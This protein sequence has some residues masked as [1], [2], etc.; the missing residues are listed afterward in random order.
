MS[1]KPQK[2]RENSKFAAPARANGGSSPLSKLVFALVAALGALALFLQHAMPRPLPHGALVGLGAAL[3]AAIGV[4]GFSGAI[5]FAR[6]ASRRRSGDGGLGRLPGEHWLV[7]LRV[8]LPLSVAVLVGGVA[9]FGYGGLPVTITC[10]LVALLPPAARRPGLLLAVLVSLLY[11]PLLGVSALWDPWETHYAEVAR[12]ILSRRDW[13]SLWWAQDGWFWSK[14]ILVFWSEALTMSALGVDPAPD[15]NPLHPEWALRLPVFAMSLAALVAVHALVRRMFGPRAGLLA[16]LVLATAPHFFLLAHQSITDMPL[17][18]CLTV[19]LCFLMLALAEDPAREPAVHSLGP[20]RLS[21]RTAALVALVLLALPQATYLISRN[22]SL[23]GHGLVAHEDSFQYGS[24][25][26]QGVSGNPKHQRS[27]PSARWRLGPALGLGPR[28]PLAGVDLA[29]PAAQGALWL[30]LL[31]IAAFFVARERRVQGLLMVG[32]YISCA[33]GL[34]AK[35]LPALALPGLIALLYLIGSGRFGALFRG[36]LRVALGISI[37]AVIGFPWYLAMS[38]R[39]GKPFLDRLLIHDHVNRLTSGVHGDSGSLQYFLREL[40]YALFP[41]VALAPAAVAGFFWYKRAAS[42]SRDRARRDREETLVFLGLWAVTAFALFSAMMTKF[43]HYIF[44]AVPPIA[45]L[46]GILLDRLWGE[47]AVNAP[48]KIRALGTLAALASAPLLVLGVA[49]RF[50]DVRG[51]IPAR[52]PEAERLDWIV[53][54]P[55]SGEIT[56]GL[57]ASGLLLAAAAFFALKRTSSA[58]RRAFAE[59]RRLGLS[60]AMLAGASVLAFVGR[61]MSWVTPTRPQGYELLAHLFVYNY[62]RPWPPHFDYRPILSGFALVATSLVVLAAGK[63]LQPLM[64]RAFLGLAIAF[65]A[66]GVNVYMV[67]L[68]DHWSIRPLVERYYARRSGPEEPIVAWQMNWKG[69]NFYT[70]NRVHVFKQLDNRAVLEWVAKNE[71]TRAFFALE[72]TRL[73]SFRGLM[74]RRAVR[75]LTTERDCN[76][77]VLVEVTL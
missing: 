13:I 64:A 17:V 49:G 38:V 50:G 7:S 43:H 34:M 35:G 26:N 20:L 65:A 68:A 76:K 74:Q 41:W 72:R 52:V 30:T 48:R 3:V 23:D 6:G 77:F 31:G 37:V 53:R 70:G 21:A 16:G 11:L 59:P 63:R 46:S 28:S 47:A 15:A 55:W 42:D 25:G 58:E 69:E 45:I 8:A 54:H 56:A 24:A 32:F 18:A 14:P 4:A 40:G 2:P 12:E 5:G 60:V 39:H 19:S 71:G 22:V 73:P 51:R 67:D 29:Q 1:R 27:H 36:E 9:L 33:L 62:G 44:P 66:W 61:D 10:A 75:E 57:F